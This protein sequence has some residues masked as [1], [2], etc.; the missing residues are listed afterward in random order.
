MNKKKE[1]LTSLIVGLVIILI[2]L[3]WI[4]D[5][6]FMLYAYYSTAVLYMF[7]YPDWVLILNSVLGLIG[8]WIGIKVI[9]QKIKIKFGT[10]I[11]FSILV[12]GGL[13]KF[14][15]MI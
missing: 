12:V 9:R 4:W 3:Y 13:V 7:R 1:K 8:L 14:L 6:S 2:N 10:F 15:I 5:N 11:S